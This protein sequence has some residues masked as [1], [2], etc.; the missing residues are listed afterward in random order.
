MGSRPPC[1]RV[2]L[3]FP[4]DRGRFRRAPEFWNVRSDTG[5]SA[6]T[7]TSGGPVCAVSEPA[8]FVGDGSFRR[9]RAVQAHVAIRALGREFDA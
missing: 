5:G 3:R 4:E 8:R 2:R 7:R 6:G 1:F 9:E